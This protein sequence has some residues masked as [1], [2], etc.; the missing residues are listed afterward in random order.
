MIAKD[1]EMKSLTIENGELSQYSGQTI[2][3][4]SLKHDISI[5][6]LYIYIKRRHLILNT[7][8]KAY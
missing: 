1:V 8:S 4:T 6:N 3:W 7:H 5:I 2:Y